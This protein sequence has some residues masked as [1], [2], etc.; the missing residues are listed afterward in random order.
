MTKN[1]TKIITI[2]SLV[3]F[4]LAFM[5]S[6]RLWFRLDFTK[7]K[8]HTISR[9]SRNL[10]TE[11]P[12]YVNVTYYLSNRLR[13]V[14]PAP[15][16]IEDMLRE[17]AAHSKGKI[18]VTVRDPA[19]GNLSAVVE[20]LGLQP[21]QVQTVERDQASFVTVYSGIVIEY[22][23]RIEV[24]PWVISVDTLEYDLASRIRSMVTDTERRVGIIIGDSFRQLRE[25]FG[26]LHRMLSESGYRIRYL[27]PGDEIPDNLPA[28]FVLGGVEDLD[29]WAL[30]RIDRFIQL[31]G[32]VFFAVK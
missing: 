12:D 24:I 2:L 20:E 19:R 28:I 16:E 31:G 5:V 29:P 10:H 11:I 6:H 23:D 1:Q 32:N 25:D 13:A 3:V 14:I 26:F 9:V 27:F 18:R 30:Y 8:A 7:S 17:F 15:G 21:R 4:A 22:L